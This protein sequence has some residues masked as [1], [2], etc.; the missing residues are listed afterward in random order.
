MTMKKKKLF[1]ERGFLFG[2]VSIVDILAVLLVL[3]LVLM[4][5]VRFFT[6]D[7]TN[8]G[9][10]SDT[11]KVT[12]DYV[13]KIAAARQCHAEAFQ[14]GDT[15]YNGEY[16]LVVGTVKEIRT[17]EATSLLSTTDGRVLRVPLENFYDI[18]IT[19]TAECS[20]SA[21]G[22]Y[23]FGTLELNRN[24]TM[25]IWTM[26]DSVTGTVYSVT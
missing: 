14:P 5:Y 24:M 2:K 13:L 6:D 12:V 15:V 21:G 4:L 26:Y 3:A 17:E 16:G 20:T 10:V 11:G 22:Y 9:S 18:Y 23:L 8:P 25:T 7:E 19:I 1:D